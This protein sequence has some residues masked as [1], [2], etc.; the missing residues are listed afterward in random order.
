MILEFKGSFLENDIDIYVDGEIKRITKNQ[1]VQFEIREHKRYRIEIESQ[2]DSANKIKRLKEIIFE[3][4]TSPA[5][6]FWYEATDAIKI[7]ASFDYV[8]SNDEC[9]IIR[10]EPSYYRLETNKWYAPTIYVNEQEILDCEYECKSTAFNKHIQQM[11]VMNIMF[12]MPWITLFL[13]VFFYVP[14]NEFMN[15][16]IMIGIFVGLI[17]ISLWLY[18]T[19]AKQDCE[20]AIKALQEWNHE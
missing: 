14:L 5:L 17:I 6:L 11:A 18:V 12:W 10:H 7:K 8:G 15:V 9:L 1:K 16:V 20:I 3:T 13:N 19:S 4:Q 2:I